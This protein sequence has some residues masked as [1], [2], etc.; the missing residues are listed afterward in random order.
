MNVPSIN[1]M[2]TQ[3]Y[4][5]NND[6]FSSSNP[7]NKEYIQKSINATNPNVTSNTAQNLYSQPDNRFDPY[8]GYL[9]KEGLLDDGTNKRR[10]KAHYININSADR[11]IIPTLILAPPQVLS[12]NPLVFNAGSNIV[13]VTHLNNGFQDGDLITM[14]HVVSTTI[15]LNT[16]DSNGNPSFIIPIGYD[17]MVIFAQHGIPLYY[18]GTSLTVEIQGIQGDRG[19]PLTTSYL[20][21]IP[22]NQINAIFPIYLTLTQDELNLPPNMTYSIGTAS[23]IGFII[24]GVGTTFTSA[25]IGGTIVYANDVV[26]PITGFTDTTHLITTISQT[27]ANQSYVISYSTVSLPV[28]GGPP[29]FSTA[30]ASNNYFFIILPQVM[31]QTYTLNSYNYFL[32]Y[33]TI[34]GVPLGSLNAGLPIGPTMN[35]AFH[36]L[37]NVTTNG[38][39]F[40]L[41]SP[42]TQTILNGGGGSNVTV[43]LVTDVNTGYTY[44]NS[45]TISLTKTFRN[46]VQARLVSSEFPNSQQA[47]NSSN[48]N[49]YW[50][51]I[52]D[53]D[54]LY[55][56]TIPPGNYTPSDLATEISDLF[57]AVPRIN[58]GT[59]IGSGIVGYIPYTPFHYIQVTI[60]TNTNVVSMSSLK[61]YIVPNPFVAT[62]PVITPTTTSQVSPIYT[63]TVNQP[64]HG[65]TVP[66]Q[67]IIIEG[68]VEYSGI[69]ANI[70]NG[71][72]FVNSIIDNSHYTFTLA[73]FNLDILGIPTTTPATGSGGGGFAVL[74]YIPDLW[75]LRFDQPN[76][77]A[78]VLGWRNPGDPNS[79]TT[80]ATIHTNQDAYAFDSLYD[81]SGNPL[82]ITN[83]FLQLSGGNYVYMVAEPLEAY[84]STGAIPKAFAKILL[85]D[86]PDKVLFNSYVNMPAIYDNPLNELY[87]LQIAFYSVDGTLYDFN[88]V[89]H[90]FTLEII[91]VHDFPSGTHISASTG[92]NYNINAN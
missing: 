79:I 62:N 16:Y 42:A 71:E 43:S 18:T 13:D 3:N 83:N 25:M 58:S 76:S 65:M 70:L 39:Q 30:V 32:I 78:S 29:T 89:D 31:N 12:P 68:A 7:M 45:Y 26:A 66:G 53:G 46:I 56:I 44:P 6:A 92:K 82:I 54:Y 52:D 67:T 38:Y 57:F 33:Q 61:Q 24:T 4:H 8:T 63:I 84:R 1:P 74:I 59:S 80:Y 51:D 87:Q 28:T 41:T 14:S 85:C 27:I 72:Q 75:R 49:I 23:Q 86:L 10:F 22:I 34:G 77:A 47:I 9:F 2:N 90:S 20:G 91:T 64:G 40:V 50:N 55:H 21:N 5:K 15:Q 11:D 60:N 81:V 48:N 73:P 17:F 88:G 35:S 19:S 36:T 37:Q 69:A